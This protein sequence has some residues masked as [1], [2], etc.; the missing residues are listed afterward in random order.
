LDD[1]LYTLQPE[2]K[3]LKKYSQ[4]KKYELLAKINE[5]TTDLDKI[6]PNWSLNTVEDA[7]DIAVNS[8]A[9]KT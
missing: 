5:I 9:P 1:D 8:I 2:D 4:M 6:N 7:A 3:V